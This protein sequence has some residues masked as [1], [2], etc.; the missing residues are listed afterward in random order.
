MNLSDDMRRV[1]KS[2]S[3]SSEHYM[4]LINSRQADY[5]ITRHIVRVLLRAKHETSLPAIA[6]AESALV[7]GKQIHHTSI[8]NSEKVYSSFIVNKHPTL[9]WEIWKKV[10][11]KNTFDR[12]DIDRALKRIKI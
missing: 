4:L 9:I 6:A 7:P 12:E 2:L 11:K 3:V 10:Y 5:M 8:L 1:Y